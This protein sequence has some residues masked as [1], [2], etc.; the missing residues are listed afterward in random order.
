MN[1]YGF[2]GF[3]K[4]QIVN[5]TEE[6][7]VGRNAKRDRAI[8]LSRFIDGLTY[9]QIAEVYGLSVSQVKRIVYRGEKIIFGHVKQGV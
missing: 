4:T 1:L 7:I 8:L 9:E 5:L 3:G 2:C 6:W